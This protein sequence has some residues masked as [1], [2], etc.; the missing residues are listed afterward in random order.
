[1]SEPAIP[2]NRPYYVGAEVEHIEAA[3]RSGWISSGGE[4]SARCQRL[5]KERIGSAAALVTHSCTAGLEGAMLL[6]GVGPGDEVIMPSYTFVTTAS[7]VAMRGATPVFV[8]IRSDTLNIDEELIEDAIT[9]RTAAIVPIHYAGV[10][11]EMDAINAIAQPRGIKVIEDAAQGLEAS[12]R[13]KPL[14]SLGDYGTLSF[15]ETKNVTC[16]EGGALLVNAEKDVAEAEVVWEKGT[17]RA[18]FARGEVE[19]YTWV[20]LGS[21]FGLSE[22]TAA[23][24]WTQL[25]HADE[26]T[27]LRRRIWERY[28]EAFAEAEADGRIRRAVIPDH[29]EHNAHMYY[30]LLPDNEARTRFIAALADRSILAVFHYVPLHTSPAGSRLGRAHGSLANTEDLSGRLVRLPLWAGMEPGVIDEVIDAADEAIERVAPEGAIE[31]QA[32]SR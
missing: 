17:N 1:V 29:C 11:A 19:R 9:D 13:G 14:G 8:D 26:I 15:H 16:G 4:Y 18:Q 10:G 22:V 32:S 21:S 20:E 23:F 12:Y 28:H 7:S 2:F 31:A 3:V 24:L 25:E 6:S 30:L 27:A 5:L